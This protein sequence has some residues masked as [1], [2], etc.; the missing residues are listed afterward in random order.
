MRENSAAPAPAKPGAIDFALKGL[1]YG[2]LWGIVVGGARLMW[3]GR[4]EML[5]IVA[6]CF[7]LGFGFAGFMM[8]WTR[9]WERDGGPG[10]TLRFVM[11]G[12]FGGCF[13][14]LAMFAV[15]GE[16]ARAL[17]IWPLIGLFGGLGFRSWS[18]RHDAR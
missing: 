5:P 1:K 14:G 12:A 6:S 9:H 16:G 13:V 15:G 10:R 18:A 7:T 11:S 4:I 3:R 8:F 17:V 2:A